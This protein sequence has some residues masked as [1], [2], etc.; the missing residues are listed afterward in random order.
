MELVSVFSDLKKLHG[1]SELVSS[2]LLGIECNTHG[3]D[4]DICLSLYNT[5]L[6]DSSIDIDFEYH[7]R[8]LS[9]RGLKARSF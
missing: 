4:Y 8:V 7:W 1:N 6:K 3:F 9:K 2:D 5:W